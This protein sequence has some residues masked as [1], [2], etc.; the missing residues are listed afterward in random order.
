MATSTIS[1]II[2]VIAPQYASDPREA[3]LI[4]LQKLFISESAFGTRYNYAVALLVC[5]VYALE[6]QSGG[7]PGSAGGT[8]SG[9]A[10][11]GNIASRKEG[12]LAV[13]YKHDTYSKDG[14]KY[15]SQTTFGQQ[16]ISLRNMLILTFGNRFNL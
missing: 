15:L 14:D 3:D 5:H 12:D 8:S 6:S 16:F 10:S 4:D 2:A 13:S 7:N 11:S 9:S 1:E